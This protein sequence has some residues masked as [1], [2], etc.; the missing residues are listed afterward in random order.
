MDGSL[1]VNWFFPPC[2]FLRRRF[3]RDFFFRWSAWWRRLFRRTSRF[4]RWRW[5]SE[6]ELE[7]ELEELLELV[8]SLSESSEGD[9][10]ESLDDE[11]DGYFLRRP[12]DFFFFLRSRRFRGLGEGRLSSSELSDESSS[13]LLFVRRADSD[14]R[15]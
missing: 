6:P 13:F 1:R 10:A 14:F 8:S 3:W 7:L 11:S 15:P 5:W 2:F 9:P 12:L 4:R